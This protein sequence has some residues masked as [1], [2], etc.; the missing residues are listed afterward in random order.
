[1]KG[2]EKAKQSKYIKEN[3]Y[4]LYFDHMTTRKPKRRPK[5][6]KRPLPQGPK[7]RRRQ[8]PRKTLE[9]FTNG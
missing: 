4:R 1:M 8:K 6:T 3:I 9:F 5:T 7:R 2:K